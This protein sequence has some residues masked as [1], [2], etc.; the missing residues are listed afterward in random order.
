MPRFKP[1]LPD[2]PLESPVDLEELQILAQKL[3]EDGVLAA[4]EPDQLQQVLSQ[5][6]S[7]LGP[8]GLA[9]LETLLRPLH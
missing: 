7:L 5:F 8:E 1:S 4:L 2:P 3:T 6:G 9:M